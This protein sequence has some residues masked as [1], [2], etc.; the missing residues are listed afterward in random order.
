MLVAPIDPEFTASPLLDKLLRKAASVLRLSRDEAGDD[1]NLQTQ[2][3]E[4]VDEAITRL[5]TNTHKRA[6]CLMMKCVKLDREL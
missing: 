5:P 1:G 6:A 4:Q 3:Y 2:C